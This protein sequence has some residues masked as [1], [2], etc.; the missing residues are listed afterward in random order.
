MALR[1]LTVSMATQ[2]LN[3][4]Q[5]VVVCPL[6]GFSFMGDIM[7][8]GLTMRIFQ[9]NQP[10]SIFHR[11]GEKNWGR[12]GKSSTTSRGL[13]KRLALNKRLS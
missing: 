3:S 5:W 12:A 8:Q 11:V 1:L 10:T 9:N 13:R 2:A 6:V 7:A 4:G